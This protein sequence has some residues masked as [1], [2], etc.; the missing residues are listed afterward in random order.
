MVLYTS[1]Y[2]TKKTAKPVEYCLFDLR[3]LERENSCKDEV[4]SLAF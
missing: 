3:T 1:L 2:I 4:S